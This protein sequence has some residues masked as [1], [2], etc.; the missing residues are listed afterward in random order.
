MTP[1]PQRPPGTL[2]ARLL[3]LQEL[4]VDPD[5]ARHLVPLCTALGAIVVTGEVAARIDPDLSEEE[6]AAGSKTWSRLSGGSRAV[7]L[8]P[9]APGDPRRGLQRA[10]GASQSC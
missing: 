3:G 8:H 6:R 1:A 2:A 9:G 5:S 10:T 7:V 4:A